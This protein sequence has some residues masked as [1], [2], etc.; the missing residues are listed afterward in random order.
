MAEKPGTPEAD[1]PW[2]A[3]AKYAGIGF[4]VAIV[5]VL[6][7]YVGARLDSWL[8]KSPLFLLICLIL[9]FATA[10]NIILKYSRMAERDAENGEGNGTEQ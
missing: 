3:F 2:V 6:S 8:D 10:I 5:T 4:E 9:G 1:S 7:I